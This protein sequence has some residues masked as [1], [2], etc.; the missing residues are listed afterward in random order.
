[1]CVVDDAGRG[2]LRYA[3][4]SSDG[5]PGPLQPVF[6]SDEPDV[7]YADLSPDGSSLAMAVRDPN[8]QMNVVLTPFP[9][10]DRR[11]IVT[12]DGGTAPRFAPDGRELF[13]LSGSRDTVGGS[14][15]KLMRVP[16]TLHPSIAIGA[17]TAL[18]AESDTLSF[19]GFSVSPDGQRF[20]MSAPAPAAPGEGPRVVLVQNWVAGL[21][22]SQAP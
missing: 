12:T 8:G 9:S 16:I 7:S 11:W 22:K 3:P 20:L 19:A 18:F 1:V 21:A 5:L 17:P 2:R 15:G 10:A 13:Y 4:L 6:R 14:Y